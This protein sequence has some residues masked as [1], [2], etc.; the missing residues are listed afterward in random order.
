MI[1]DNCSHWDYDD[2]CDEYYCT[3]DLDEDEICRFYECG[4]TQCPYYD[5]YDEYGIVRKQ[6]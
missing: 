3:A 6:N 1:C 2:E 5:P 4:A